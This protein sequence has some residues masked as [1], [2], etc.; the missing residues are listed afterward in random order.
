MTPA[1]G[2]VGCHDAE[3]GAADA[4]SSSRIVSVRSAGSAASATRTAGRRRAR[5]PQGLL[6]RPEAIRARRSTRPS[7]TRAARRT[8]VR[9]RGGREGRR[10]PGRAPGERADEGEGLDARVA[11]EVGTIEDRLSTTPRRS[12]ILFAGKSGT[13]RSAMPSTLYAAA[14]SRSAR[15]LKP[16]SSSRSR[17][18]DG[19][20]RI[21]LYADDRRASAR[22]VEI[23]VPP[24]NES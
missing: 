9:G 7:P 11:D 2:V 14:S 13:T 1:E 23:F 10:R 4:M 5:R 16:E 24:R 12:P 8:A 15:N 6:R 20:R 3:A 19:E 21:A 22:P 17:S 18:R